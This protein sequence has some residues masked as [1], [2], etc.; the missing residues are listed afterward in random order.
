MPPSDDLVNA[1]SQVVGNLVNIG[2]IAAS[3]DSDRFEAYVWSLIVRAAQDENAD[4]T[5]RDPYKQLV[6]DLTFRTS[7]GSLSTMSPAYT[8]AQIVFAGKPEL[9]AHVGVKVQGKSRV[10]HECD[11]LVLPAEEADT[12]RSST[13]HPRGSS[14]V[15]AAE[16]KYYYSNLPFRLCRE[17]LGLC[18]EMRAVDCYFAVNTSKESVEKVLAYY[19]S[20]CETLVLPTAA[21]SE[22]L[23][24][25]FRRAFRDYKRLN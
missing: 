21:G 12:S 3:A 18:K 15:I 25:T 2:A 19:R 5:Y 20:N 23:I 14:I 17:F 7:P 11:V 1:I 4:V 9:E 6:T 8:H 10:P 13:A 24:H 16:C 22:T